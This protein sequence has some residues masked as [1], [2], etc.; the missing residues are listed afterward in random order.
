MMEN[1]KSCHLKSL[2]AL[3]IAIY[4]LSQRSTLFLQEMSVNCCRTTMC[5]PIVL[6]QVNKEIVIGIF[7]SK[8]YPPLIKTTRFIISCYKGAATSAFNENDV[9]ITLGNLV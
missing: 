7:A 6:L 8:R 1:T 5:K 2:L 4:S 9:I 3:N